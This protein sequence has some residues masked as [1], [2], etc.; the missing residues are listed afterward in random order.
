MDSERWRRIQDLCAEALERPSVERTAFLE[1]ACRGDEPLRREV[2]N[3]LRTRTGSGQHPGGATPHGASSHDGGLLGRQIGKYEVLEKIGQGG[4]GT[5]YKGRDAMLQRLVAIKTCSNE[6]A[7]L[8]R[9]FFR[10]AKIGANLQHPNVTTVIELGVEGEVPYLVQEYLPGHDLKELIRNGGLS[11]ETKLHYLVQAARGLAYAHEQGVVHRDVKPANVRVMKDGTVKIMDFGIARMMSENTQLTATGMAMGTVGYLA[12]EQLRGEPI[13]ARVDVFS[14][15]V[16]AYEVFSGKMPFHGETFAEI[17]LKILQKNPV[18]L[19]DVWPQCPD[20]SLNHLVNR[21][22][23]KE[24][25]DRFERMIDVAAGLERFLSGLRSGLAPAVEGP[26]RQISAQQISAN[27]MSRDETLDFGPTL[28]DDDSAF[29]RDLEQPTAK[30]SLTSMAPPPPPGASYEPTY[31]EEQAVPK[32][33]ASAVETATLPIP[34]R[35]KSWLPIAAGAIVLIVGGVFLS[36]MGVG[37]SPTSSEPAP[38]PP[39]VVDT[40]ETASSDA[41]DDPNDKPTD[42]GPSGGDPTESEPTDSESTQVDEAS[43]QPAQAETS[44][45]SPVDEAAD[46]LT[47]TAP[48][49]EEPASTPGGSEPAAELADTEE[50]SASGIVEP[51]PSPAPTEPPAQITATP[52]PPT[53]TPPTTSTPPS[54]TPPRPPAPQPATTPPPPAPGEA[55][56]TT[57]AEPAMQL[58]APIAGSEPGVVKP[59]LLEKAPAEYPPLARRKRVGGQVVVAVYVDENGNVTNAVVSK[60]NRSIPAFNKAAV[61]AARQCRFQPATRDGIAGKMWTEITYDFKPGRRTGGP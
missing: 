21:C 24:A 31:K 26:T 37:P 29:A 61:E 14:F 6:N 16:M 15:G 47:P 32:P 4:F 33:N 53:A 34:I 27:P 40:A 13:D 30:P 43:V 49:E 12:P 25:E 5:V 8:R 18:P 11:T 35:R 2:E 51:T 9:R 41:A 58:G 28:A 48:A 36:R 46:R 59:V 55:T 17:S 23:A 52:P 1:G 39:V 45:A 38:P 3:L 20:P 42:S 50:A 7:E 44:P 19:G 22:M 10:E 60:G 57:P 54:P 56:P